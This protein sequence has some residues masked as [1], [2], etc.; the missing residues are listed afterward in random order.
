[1]ETY[2]TTYDYDQYVDVYSYFITDPLLRND[3]SYLYTYLQ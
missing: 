2:I 3:Y 1:M